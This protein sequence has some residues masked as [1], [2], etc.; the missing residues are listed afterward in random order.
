MQVMNT[1][2]TSAVPLK[3]ADTR[4]LLKCPKCPSTFYSKSG[5]YRHIKKCGEVKVSGRKNI[6]KFHVPQISQ[7]AA[8]M[9]TRP[10]LHPSVIQEDKSTSRITYKCPQCPSDFYSKSGFYKHVK[11]CKAKKLN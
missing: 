2:Q 10:V 9:F 3:V 8:Q 5:Y 4:K 6:E 7:P 1:S 11:R